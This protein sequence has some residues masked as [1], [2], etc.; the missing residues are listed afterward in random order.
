M[1]AATDHVDD[2]YELGALASHRTAFYRRVGWEPW[3]G[4]LAVRSPHGVV[5]TPEEAGAIL[6]R[7]T[8]SSPPL[9]A[10]GLLTCDWRAGDVW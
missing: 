5:E 3:P 4:Q 8:P 9:V 10:G 7:R 2:A 6:V 1:R